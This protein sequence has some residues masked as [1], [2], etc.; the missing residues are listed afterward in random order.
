MTQNQHEGVSPQGGLDPA[1]K[2]RIDA[3]FE[4]GTGIDSDAMGVWILPTNS[5]REG[6]WNELESLEHYAD[7]VRR[8]NADPGAADYILAKSTS[9]AI[10]NFNALVDEFNKD[11]ERI[12][13][14]QDA[15]TVEAFFKHAKKLILNEE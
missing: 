9:E 11:L 7:Y 15:T 3:G 5:A 10:K 2:E 12:R 8:K 1:R 14:E 6:V 4:T 13:R